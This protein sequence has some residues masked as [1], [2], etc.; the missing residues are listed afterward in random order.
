MGEAEDMDTEHF[1]APL[2]HSIYCVQHLHCPGGE[3]KALQKE[4]EGVRESVAEL[5]LQ[6][7]SQDA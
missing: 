6:P 2:S 5:G 3:T 1:L 7:T 4:E